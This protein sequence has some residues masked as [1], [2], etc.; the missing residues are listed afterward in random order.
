VK[1]IYAGIITSA[2]AVSMVFFPAVVLDS[3]K[4]G[5]AL[6]AYS[7]LPALLPFFICADFMISL[8]GLP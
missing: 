8:A 6:W 3:A 1:Y 4:R 2:I 5:I 7:V